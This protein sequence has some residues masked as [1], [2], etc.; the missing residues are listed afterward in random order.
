VRRGFSH[1]L[2]GE[3]GRFP[4]SEETERGEFCWG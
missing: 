3:H 2:S 4:G 1:F